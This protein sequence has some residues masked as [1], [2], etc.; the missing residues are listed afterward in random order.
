[1]L[2]EPRVRVWV[3]SASCTVTPK[4]QNREGCN[5][6][7]MFIFPLLTGKEYKKWDIFLK[8]SFLA[9][10]LWHWH[11][12]FRIGWLRSI[13]GIYDFQ[14]R[15]FCPP[16][17][18]RQERSIEH[19]HTSPALLRQFPLLQAAIYPSIHPSWLSLLMMH[20]LI[21]CHQ[22]HVPF[23]SNPTSGVPPSSCHPTHCI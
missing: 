17:V 13:M 10:W 15:K 20:H 2:L 19:Q 22:V 3:S 21:A 1:M 7:N 16:L 8:E 9:W 5:H 23:I 18:A 4:K 6:P 14:F 11:Y 12:V